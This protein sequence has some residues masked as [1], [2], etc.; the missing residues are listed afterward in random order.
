MDAASRYDSERKMRLILKHGIRRGDHDVAQENVFGMYRC[1]TV[2]GRDYRHRDIKQVR[3]NLLPL[4]I[5]LVIAPRREKIEACR[6][7]AVDESVACAGQNYH[8]IV[9]ILSDL[10]K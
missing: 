10:M 5:D 4:S 7:D 9:G 1:W 6:V 3:Q 2:K 8:A